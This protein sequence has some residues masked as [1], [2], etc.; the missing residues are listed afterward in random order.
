MN[1]KNKNGGFTMVE[2]LAV[3]ILLIIIVA[4]S[5]PIYIKVE[6]NNHEKMLV[7]QMENIKNIAGLYFYNNSLT[8]TFS[9]IVFTCGNNSCSYK[10]EKL[11]IEGLIPTSGEIKIDSKGVVTFNNI[12]LDGY[13]CKEKQDGY[14][15]IEL[16]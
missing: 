8:G 2:L 10:G 3:I 11:N 16:N 9:E 15:C 12:I 1:K 6:K 13:N 4:I 14:E 7:N 5:V